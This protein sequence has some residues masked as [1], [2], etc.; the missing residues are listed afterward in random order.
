MGQSAR[1]VLT[2]LMLFIPLAALLTGALPDPPAQAGPILWTLRILLPLAFVAGVWAL[3]A[4][5]RR[6]DRLP[7]FL[8]QH[9]SHFFE[10]DGFCFAIRPIASDGVCFFE[11]LYQ[12]RYDRPSEARVV[13][14]RGVSRIMTIPISCEGGAFGVVQAPYGVHANYRGTTR[15]F[16][17]SAAV[18]YP[19]GKG[20]PVRFREGVAVGKAKLNSW[21]GAA[22]AASL[23]MLS[24]ALS[25][26][27]AQLP[28][29]SCCRP[30][31]PRSFQMKC[32][33]TPKRFGGR[34][35]R[36]SRR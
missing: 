8:S 20:Q 29:N 36:W 2:V 11:L 16:E 33:S 10:R 30:T 13:I 7:D 1:A 5:A 19:Q 24:M 4:S 6:K 15:K 22:T 18:R 21:A 3:V 9:V 31:S 25:Q 35:T 27:T 32:P 28:C 34:A 12:N 14:S 23:A 26:P 17:V